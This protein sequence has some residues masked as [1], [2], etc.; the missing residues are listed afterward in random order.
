MT[1]MVNA[2]TER[3]ERRIEVH[4]GPPQEQCAKDALKREG[5]QKLLYRAQLSHILG[6][7]V[8]AERP[9]QGGT[10]SLSIA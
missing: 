1:A 4:T 10:K 9:G 8:S 7:Y 5:C 2:A 3:L 6:N